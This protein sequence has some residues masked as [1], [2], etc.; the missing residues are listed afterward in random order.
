MRLIDN[1]GAVVKNPEHGEVT[2]TADEQFVP[3]DLVFLDTKQFVTCNLNGMISSAALTAGP[4]TALFATDQASPD[5]CSGLRLDMPDGDFVVFAASNDATN[6]KLIASRYSSA[7]GLLAR[8]V[9]EGVQAA[10]MGNICATVLS[11]GNIALGY[12]KG[13]TGYWRLLGPTLTVLAGASVGSNVYYLQETNNGGF[14]MVATDTIS[15]VSAT[16]SVTSN[17]ISI[18]SLSLAM[19]DELNDDQRKLYN[20]RCYS[21]T[22]YAPLAISDGGWMFVYQNPTGVQLL[23]FNSDGTVRGVVVTLWTYG[24]QT[25]GELRVARS[26]DVGGPICW[27]ASLVSNAGSYGVVGDDGSIVKA[28]ATLSAVASAG[29]ARFKLLADTDGDFVIVG[30]DTTPGPWNILYTSSVGVAKATYP[31]Q[32]TTNTNN[33][34][35][36]LLRLSTGLAL[37]CVPGAGYEFKLAWIQNGGGSNTVSSILNFN[38]GDSGVLSA[39]MVVDDVVYGGCTAGVGGSADLALFTI[40]NA[41][42]VDT[43]PCFSGTS[44]SVSA[45]D[46][47]IGIEP[48]LNIIHVIGNGQINSFRLDKTFVQTYLNAVTL[49]NA[50]FKFI[51]GGYFCHDSAT[52]GAAG[53][54]SAT[55]TAVLVV[56]LRPTILLGVSNDTAS[57]GQPLMIK[58][59]GV[60]A[61]TYGSTAKSFDQSANDPPGQKGW[62]NSRVV[63]LGGF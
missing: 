15:F 52:G 18:E 59:K 25:V 24:S 38:G 42:V 50:K 47:S 30:S 58:T 7:G 32:L 3:Q 43:A 2:V 63:A 45:T 51:K 23:R 22:N 56:K 54:G 48:S 26:G 19:Q 53:P 31:K 4:A 61:T 34:P 1:G 46:L 41:G 49:G 60:H 12:R 6:Y 27:V 28:Q 62:I 55:G 40:S 37:V 29:G 35:A 44:L 10:T 36:K 11:N 13:S 16:G 9:I 8:N 17:A 21:R 39:C 33:R 5:A 57:V 20:T 14:L